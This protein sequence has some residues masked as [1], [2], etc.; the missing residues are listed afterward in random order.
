VTAKAT[1]EKIRNRLWRSV[2]G[3]LN[4]RPS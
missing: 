3:V 2:R 4:F 1:L